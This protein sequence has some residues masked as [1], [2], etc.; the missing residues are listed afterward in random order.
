MTAFQRL[1]LRGLQVDEMDLDAVVEHIREGGIVIYPT[2]TVYGIG[3]LLRP[4]PLAVVQRFKSRGP[5]SPFLVLVPDAES[6]RGLVW[7]PA[8]SEMLPSQPCPPALSS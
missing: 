1:D 2:E 8:A 7:T 6:V 3:C 5:R 4:E